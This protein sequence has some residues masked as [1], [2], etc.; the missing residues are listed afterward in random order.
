MVHALYKS[1]LFSSSRS[2][3]KWRRPLLAAAV[4]LFA[5]MPVGAAEN[6]DRVG[7]LLGGMS[8]ALREQSYQGL[9]TYEHGG[10]LETLKLLHQVSDGIE[11][12]SL[13]HL[14]G[15]A[16]R[17]SPSARKTDC[18]SPSDRRL[19]GLLPEVSGALAD[20]ATHY[21]FY[22][23]EDQR[24]AGREATVLQI[25]PRDEYRFGHTFTIDKAT[26][27]P[28]GAMIFTPNKTV[29]ER[30]QFVDL[31]LLTDAEPLAVAPSAFLCQSEPAPQA[32][33]RV[34]WMPSGFM[35]AGVNRSESVGD[36]MMFTDGLSSFSVFIRRSV[37]GVAAQGQAQRGAT[38][39]FMQQYRFG[40]AVYTVSV[41]GEVP[42]RTAQRIANSIQP[43]GQG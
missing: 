16:Q 32:L 20:L 43:V 24:V 18:L 26:S 40:Q 1:F 21:H 33:W 29:L 28:L 19:R 36:M 23:R 12:S 6:L 35:S 41:V 27:L 15:P 22:I 38:V 8:Q 5:C 11:V 14:N 4:Y 37:A 25:V 31:S 9:F 13:E 3:F 10:A 17:Y 7:A 34:G 39:A 30:L 42:A 2:P